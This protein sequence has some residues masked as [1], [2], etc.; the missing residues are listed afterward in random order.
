[1]AEFE[2]IRRTQMSSI[3]DQR[4]LVSSMSFLNNVNEKIHIKT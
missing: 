1:M 3:A 4:M 2:E